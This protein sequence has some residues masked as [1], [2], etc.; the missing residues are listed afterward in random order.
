MSTGEFKYRYTP[1]EIL[2]DS[3]NFLA[4]AKDK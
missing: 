3:A 1:A 2:Q 4:S